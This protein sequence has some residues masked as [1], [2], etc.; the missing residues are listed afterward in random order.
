MFTTFSWPITERSKKKVLLILPVILL[1]LYTCQ[2]IHTRK[3]KAQEIFDITF[4]AGQLSVNL[5][6]APL[7][8]VLEEIMSQSGAKIWLTDSIDTK[9]TIEYNNVP[10]G[11]GIRRILRD[12]NY[13]FMYD[14]KEPKEGEISIVKKNKAKEIFSHPVKKSLEN[15][16]KRN[17]KKKDKD[18]SDSFEMLMKTAIEHENPED[19]IDALISLGEIK[20]KKALT[21]IIKALENDP[22]M[23]VRL[24]AID[25]L[26]DFE[27]EEI[28]EPL[29]KAAL[30][31]KDSWVRENAIKELGDIGNDKAKGVLKKALNDE[32]ASV[33]EIA[34]DILE[35]LNEVVVVDEEA[36][37]VEVEE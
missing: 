16:K 23:D 18:P 32:D 31:D 17:K 28:I 8:K 3:S 20:D 24:S 13:A 1:T 5:K 21:T 9:V 2:L 35:E 19:R 11:E 34:N 33:R 27:D 6:D 15:E 30:N 22:N 12:K 29:S 4:N 37:D 7:E 14:P 26:F 36:E 25:A 10:I